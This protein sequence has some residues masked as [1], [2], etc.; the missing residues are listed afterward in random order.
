[1]HEMRAEFVR[2]LQLDA[3]SQS[4]LCAAGTNKCTDGDLAKNSACSESLL[5]LVGG[6]ENQHAINQSIRN[7]QQYMHGS[8]NAVQSTAV[9]THQTQRLKA[10]H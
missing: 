4:G 3:V 5:F 8:I 10:E 6:I 2:I 1:M 9:N 7:K